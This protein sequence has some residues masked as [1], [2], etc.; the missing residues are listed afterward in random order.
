MEIKKHWGTVDEQGEFPYVD[1]FDN[2][3]EARAEVGKRHED[4]FL[5]TG[6]VE[7][8]CIISEDGKC[9]DESKDFYFSEQEALADLKQFEKQR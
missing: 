7:G 3:E 4:G 6:V 5:I 1:I 9:L 2:E 8:F